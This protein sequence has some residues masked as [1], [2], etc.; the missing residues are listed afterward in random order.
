VKQK[1]L[2]HSSGCTL[3]SRKLIKA[4]EHANLLRAEPNNRALWNVY[5]GYYSVA[6]GHPNLDIKGSAEAQHFLS[7]CV[8][9]CT[10]RQHLYKVSPHL[11][12]ARLVLVLLTNRTT[13]ST[14]IA[15]QEQA[16]CNLNDL[17]SNYRDYHSSRTSIH[18]PCHV[19]VANRGQVFPTI[20]PQE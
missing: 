16:C 7:H 20:A 15:Q 9:H 10:L 8:G 5:P 3:T 4:E 14:L 17:C 11:P 13:G 6:S 1:Q 18:S 19:K 12:P 2:M